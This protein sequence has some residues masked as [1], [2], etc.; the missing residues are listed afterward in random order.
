MLHKFFY[1]FLC[2]YSKSSLL[3]DSYT[4]SGIPFPWDTAFPVQFFD[5]PDYP[6]QSSWAMVVFAASMS[7]RLNSSCSCSVIC[8][9]MW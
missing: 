8:R 6:V 2:F 3:T 7:S 5:L 4:K 9:V 1:V